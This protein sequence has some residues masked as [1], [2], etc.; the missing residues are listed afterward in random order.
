MIRIEIESQAIQTRSG[1]S[2]KSGNPYT[3]REQNALVFREG[4]KYP[5]R[6]KI[7]LDDGQTPYAPGLYSLHDSSFFVNRY[8]A[9]QVRPVLSALKAGA[10][11]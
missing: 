9:L 5:E 2:S 4:E 3:I 1:V 8:D 7:N 11:S 10:S 6:I